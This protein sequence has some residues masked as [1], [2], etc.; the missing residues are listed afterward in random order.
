MLIVDEGFEDLSEESETELSEFEMPNFQDSILHDDNKSTEKDDLEHQLTKWKVQSELISKQK[1]LPSM[2]NLADIAEQPTTPQKMA[3]SL[4]LASLVEKV[5][6][7]DSPRNHREKILEKHITWKAKQVQKIMTLV[8]C[9]EEKIGD[10]IFSPMKTREEKRKLKETERLRK[11][12]EEEEEMKKRRLH[13]SQNSNTLEMEEIEAKRLEKFEARKRM[14]IE[15]REKQKQ[16][17]IKRQQEIE[18]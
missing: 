6:D 5:N 17:D 15:E 7:V 12:L 13:I 11:K 18:Q 8:T 14:I 2:P 1:R 9:K 4:P 10:V 3:L 16:E